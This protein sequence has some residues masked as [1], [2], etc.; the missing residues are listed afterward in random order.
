MTTPKGQA[1]VE[2]EMSPAPAPPSYAPEEIEEAL[3]VIQ[4]RR[5]L[6]AARAEA[7]ARYPPGY[8]KKLYNPVHKF[9]SLL[10]PLTDE[11]GEPLLDEKT[12]QQ[13]Y[14][15]NYRRFA[16]GQILAES[17]EDEAWLREVCGARLFAPDTE[18]IQ[19]CECG[20]QAYS[21]AAITVCMKSH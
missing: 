3:A 17:P 11:H 2:P 5:Q 4:A 1:V 19:T 10:V 13:R 21:H 14:S 15:S 18:E 9:E 12:G 8:P 20:W 16:N 7:E 6:D